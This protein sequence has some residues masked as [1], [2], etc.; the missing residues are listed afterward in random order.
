MFYRRW[1]HC[2]SADR[3]VAEHPDRDPA[4]RAPCQLLA[5]VCAHAGG[6]R[7]QCAACCH[8]FYH[9]PVWPNA[10]QEAD[11]GCRQ[12]QWQPDKVCNDGM[13]IS[14][15]NA[16]ACSTVV[17]TLLL[18]L[19]VGLPFAIQGH[20][21]MTVKGCCPGVSYAAKPKFHEATQLQ[22]NTPLFRQIRMIASQQ[23]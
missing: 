19:D 3:D 10:G 22:K 15:W 17:P 9:P 21:V 7:V 16:M 8:S 4:L 11:C 6:G 1:S 18:P 5:C 20:A 13:A 23:C 2:S 12:L 14:C